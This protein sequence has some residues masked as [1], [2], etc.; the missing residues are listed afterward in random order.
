MWEIKTISD[1]TEIVGGGTPKSAVSEYWDGNVQWLTPKDM[2][3]L[4]NECISST[5]RTISEVGLS[6]SSAKLVPPNSLILS[7]RAPIG[8]LA[9]N[10]VPMAFNQG[11]RGLIPNKC[12]DIRY[13]F[14]FLRG[15]VDL[16]NDLGT[17]TT[18]KELSKKA[19]AGVKIPLPPLE[20]QK[21]IVGILDEAF[22]GIDQAIAN[23]E[24]NLQNARDL[25]ESYLNNIFT[26]KDEGWSHITLGEVCQFENGDRGKNYPNRSEYV[27]RGVPWINT[28]HINPDGSL[29]AENMNFITTE[30]FKSLGGGKIQR[31]DL[32]YCLR[33]AT[34]GK[35]A[36]VEPFEEGAIASSLMIIRPTELIGK[37]YLYFYLTSRFGKMQ[38]KR[39]ENGAAQPN[40]GG[41][42]VSKFELSLPPIDEQ[43]Q[44][45]KK[46]AVLFDQSNEMQSGCRQKLTA[47][48][49]LKQSLLQKAFA[50]ELT[51][52]IMDAA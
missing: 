13:L 14:Y 26:Q 25:F 31:G 49:E 15:N 51:S 22:A 7:T 21:R 2:G 29:N 34:I 23:T 8:Y 10:E 3:K 9:I 11:C 32:V 45:A 24:K 18:F 44:I 52:E 17:G 42:S 40:L 16:L 41:K 39:F 38:I 47:L 33:G 5:I 43:G 46:M 28:G 20:E 36:F 30:K 35:T 19:L 48:K 27:E 6:K 1:V 12:I 4:S 37:L 50:G